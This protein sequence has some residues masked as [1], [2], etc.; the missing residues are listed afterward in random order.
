MREIAL[1]NEFQHFPEKVLELSL[2]QTFKMADHLSSAGSV[3]IWCDVGKNLNAAYLIVNLRDVA[4][5]KPSYDRNSKKIVKIYSR[6]LTLNAYVVSTST[7][8][9]TEEDENTVFYPGKYLFPLSE[10]SV[11]DANEFSHTCIINCLNRGEISYFLSIVTQTS[12]VAFATCSMTSLIHEYCQS[13]SR[14]R[15]F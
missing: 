13:D 1:W 2:V 7:E 11:E 12:T 9:D 4:R 15:E 3:P 6:F 10:N 14:L 8:V 5:G